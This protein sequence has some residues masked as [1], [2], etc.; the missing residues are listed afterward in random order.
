MFLLRTSLA[1]LAAAQVVLGLASSPERG[2]ISPRAET[3]Y[4]NMVYWQQTRAITHVMYAFAKVEANGNVKTRDYYAQVD[5]SKNEEFVQGKWEQLF[6][7]KKQNPHIKTL[8]SIGGWLGGEGAPEQVEFATGASTE[9]N[10]NRFAETATQLMLDGGFDGLDVDWEY[11][12]KPE[13][14][15]DHALLM[16]AIRNKLNAL[17]AS[18]NNHHFLLTAAIAA[19][20]HGHGQLKFS[21]LIPV[22]DYWY[23]MAYDYFYSTSSR[24]WHPANLYRSSSN[25]ASTD[26]STDEGIRDLLAN[27]VPASKMVLGIPSYAHTISGGIS[28]GEAMEGKNFAG[29]IPVR[30]LDPKLKVDCD[31]EI[32]ACSAMDAKE[33]KLYLF[34][35]VETIV[36]KVD[37]VKKQDLAGTFFWEISH[38]HPGDKA[39]YVAAAKQLENLESSSG[40]LEYPSSKYAA[41]RGNSVASKPL[42]EAVDSK[43][44]PVEPESPSKASEASTTLLSPPK[45]TPTTLLPPF[46]L[47]SSHTDTKPSNLASTT[48]LDHNASSPAG[49][50]SASSPTDNTSASSRGSNIVCA[51]GEICTTPRGMTPAIDADGLVIKTVVAVIVVVNVNLTA[52]A[53]PKVCAG[54]KETKTVTEYAFNT[55][56]PMESSVTPLTTV[57][58]PSDVAASEPVPV[59]MGGRVAKVCMKEFG[60]RAVDVP[61]SNRGGSYGSGSA[62][63]AGSEKVAASASAAV[64]GSGIEASASSRVEARLGCGDSSVNASASASAA[65]SGSKIKASASS[66]VE[67][68]SDCDETSGSASSSASAALTGSELELSASSKAKSRLTFNNGSGNV[69]STASAALSGS[70]AGQS[71]A[72]SLTDGSSGVDKKQKDCSEVKGS[73]RVKVSGPRD[74]EAKPSYEASRQG[75]GTHKPSNRIK[76][77]G[78][79]VTRVS[80]KAGDAQTGSKGGPTRPVSSSGIVASAGADASSN[81]IKPVIKTAEAGRLCLAGGVWATTLLSAAVVMLAL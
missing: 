4:V 3:S 24:A 45:S 28:L 7:F 8:L 29:P 25:P 54:E 46:P 61:A 52:C 9:E 56:L 63:C 70:A 48:K 22:L 51:A 5:P 18:H 39:L 40:L 44:S 41:V 60:C 57:T 53:N 38:D 64:S 2:D 75:N 66:S 33:N 34:D 67:I 74:E 78:V 15:E 14:A 20:S 49:N 23:V 72:K 71:K 31:D 68:Q 80:E 42:P 26:F 35:T 30:Q 12:R 58:L 47:N 81:V 32:V 10:R 77:G 1:T 43:P 19:G 11:P 59:T 69:S 65:L 73:S 16:E 17:E 50:S 13:E 62:L 55:R 6:E 36:K 79:D 37:Y 76:A 21:R 27:N